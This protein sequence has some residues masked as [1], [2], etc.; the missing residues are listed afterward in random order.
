MIASPLVLALV[1]VVAQTT[2]SMESSQ[3]PWT[4]RGQLQVPAMT[5][6]HVVGGLGGGI[7]VERGVF[8]LDAEAQLLPVVVCELRPKQGSQ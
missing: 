4:V 1:S 6:N 7:S 2:T 8:A 5:A 3:T